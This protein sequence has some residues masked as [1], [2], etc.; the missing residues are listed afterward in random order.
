MKKVFDIWNHDEPIAIEQYKKD[1]YMFRA[2][3]GGAY[4]VIFCSS[5][6]IW[7]P[8]TEEA[9]RQS[10]I[11]K[12]R[13]EWTNF[14]LPNTGKE[15]FVRDI[16][17]SWYVTGINT[18]VDSIDKLADFL[19]KETDGY[20]IILI[21]SSAG[22]YLASLLGALLKAEYVI[23]FSAQFE[24]RNQW[25][26]A[27]NPFLRKYEADYKR[28][29][30]YD[31]VTILRES[32]TPIYYIV[33]AKSEQDNYHYNHVKNIPCIRPIVFNNKHHG[34]VM[35]KGNLNRFLLLSQKELQMLYEKNGGKIISN[36]NF[37][38]QLEGAVGTLSALTKQIKMYWKTLKNKIKRN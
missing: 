37:S 33:P 28:S 30:Y 7:F 38:M 27:V 22:G 8:N 9:F 32:D 25:A 36:I 29:K 1:N 18:T 5:N 26:N 13:Y 3:S 11:D 19:Q 2:Y 23:A 6:N 4:C 20:K 34:I 16:Y 15:I 14:H 24:L 31:L 12:N 10:I 21:G 17:K 35:F